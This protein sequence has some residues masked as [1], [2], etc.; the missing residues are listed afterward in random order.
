MF[1]KCFDRASMSVQL[2]LPKP[3]TEIG[4]TKTKDNLLTLWYKDIIGHS[5]RQTRLSF[6]F[7]NN[8]SGTFCM[9]K[10]EL[11]G[12][13]LLITENVNLDHREVYQV[14]KNRFY[15]AYKCGM[16]ESIYDV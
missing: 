11:H 8:E 15:V 14:Y 16:V 1:L 12:D 10:F 4:S 13:Q 5:Q 9:E 7:E 2:R 3:E 6:R